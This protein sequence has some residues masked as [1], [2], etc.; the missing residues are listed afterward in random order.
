MKINRT[1]YDAIK[2]KANAFDNFVYYLEYMADKTEYSDVCVDAGIIQLLFGVNM[3]EEKK[4]T[5]LPDDKGHKK[6]VHLND[7]TESGGMQDV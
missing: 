2:E 6:N 7:T 5:V 3:K 1:E 4:P